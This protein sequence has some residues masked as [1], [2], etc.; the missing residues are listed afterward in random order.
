M[1]N[2]STNNVNR[3][4]RYRLLYTAVAMLLI[5]GVF[6][7]ISNRIRPTTTSITIEGRQKLNTNV[8]ATTTS[9]ISKQDDNTNVER[10]TEKSIRGGLSEPSKL[11]WAEAE[12]LM[13]PKKNSASRRIYVDL[14]ANCG[15]SYWRAKLGKSRGTEETLKKPSP[16]VWETYLWECNPQLIDWFLNDLVKSEPN[17]VLI[18]KAA[19]TFNG[20]ITFH[21][22][23]G[24]EQMTKEQ[25]PNPTCDPDSQYQ[26]GSAS[27][28][29]LNAKR[30][31]GSLT[32]DTVNFLEWH[33]SLQ[34]VKGDSVH[35]KMDIEGAEL[36]IIEAFLQDDT[37]QMCYW[38]AFWMEYHKEIFLKGTA[39]YEI[40]ENFENNFPKQFE[41]RCG[42]PLWPNVYI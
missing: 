3:P 42:R 9:T 21:L 5:M 22:T 27:T 24:Q 1:S 25:M 39:D 35:M 10:Q 19:S 6:N 32:V 30:A 11:S 18:P 26:P 17:V 12:S 14:G 7:L 13:L 4:G 41:V 36:D 31:G 37:N 40:H 33:K 2:S 38:D 20:N 16:E 8:V 23:A 29:Y 28:I 15:N 34:L